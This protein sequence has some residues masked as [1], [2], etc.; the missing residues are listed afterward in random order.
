MIRQNLHTHT[1][2]SDGKNTVAEMGEGALRAGCTSLGFS[3]HSPMALEIDPSMAGIDI[4]AY[5]A[6]VLRL[7]EEYA[8]RMEVFL[9]L[10]QDIDSAPSSEA[11]D[12]RIGSVHGVWKDGRYLCVDDSQEYLQQA[13][14]KHYQGDIYGFVQDFYQREAEIYRKTGCEIVGHF[15]LVTKFNE[16]GRLFQEDDPR[17]L[18]AAI[19]ALEVLLRH[20]VIFE[21]NTGAMSR[22]Y[23]S[24]PYPS[25]TLL[26]AIHE[27]GGRICITSDSHSDTT[28]MYGFELAVELARSC[29]FSETWILTQDGFRPQAL[30]P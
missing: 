11:Y 19:G 8:G 18:D 12:Y 23:R 27:R 25:S 26:R 28:I 29:G 10:E 16:G 21:I 7:R 1:I 4:A 24:L 20:D 30:I 9:G 2:F 6:E 3:E 22:G 5:R 13:V 15:D 14:E 17:C